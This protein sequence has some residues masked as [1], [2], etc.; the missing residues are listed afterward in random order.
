MMRKI[1]LFLILH[2]G[3]LYLEPFVLLRCQT[4]KFTGTV[5]RMTRLDANLQK[6][7]YDPAIL[8]NVW[9]YVQKVKELT[10]TEGLR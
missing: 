7:T 1:K 9:T 5:I 3:L 6:K 2:N 4:M 8:S 10:F